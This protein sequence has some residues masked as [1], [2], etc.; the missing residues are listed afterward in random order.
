M[1]PCPLLGRRNQA[2]CG[3]GLG[4]RFDERDPALA[5]GQ[6]GDRSPGVHRG[7]RRSV[8][9]FPGPSQRVD[10]LLVGDERAQRSLPFGARSDPPGVPRCCPPS[11]PRP[12]GRRRSGARACRDAPRPRPGA[13][14]GRRSPG[15]VRYRAR[16]RPRADEDSGAEPRSGGRRPVRLLPAPELTSSGPRRRGS[17][18]SPSSTSLIHP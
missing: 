9:A 18:A 3:L 13:D 7:N 5:S 2:L 15:R 8:H 1:E 17:Y 4:G 16:C 12:E 11:P 6:Q 14:G 10:V